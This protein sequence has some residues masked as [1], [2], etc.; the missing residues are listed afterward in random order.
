MVSVSHIIGALIE[1]TSEGLFR[2]KA[3]V[4]EEAF[5]I[6]LDTF[7]IVVGHIDGKGSFS[8]EYFIRIMDESEDVVEEIGPDSYDYHSQYRKLLL[9]L[10]TIAR[11]SARNFD[12]VMGKI[13]DY[14]ELGRRSS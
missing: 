8:S 5:V 11:R 7:S 2:W 6:S 13:G 9:E 4:N 10:F 3:M 12:E 1:R 14:L